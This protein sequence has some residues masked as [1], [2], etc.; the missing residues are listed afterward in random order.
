M[1]TAQ[2]PV[3][4]HDA[5]HVVLREQLLDPLDDLRVLLHARP[6][7]AL[8]YAISAAPGEDY[9]GDQLGG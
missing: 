3:G 1:R 2:V 5:L 7:E 4:H 6:H 8:E 9:R